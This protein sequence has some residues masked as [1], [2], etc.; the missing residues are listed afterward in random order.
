MLK[1]YFVKHF[2]IIAAVQILI[3]RPTHPGEMQIG[4]ESLNSGS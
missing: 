4:C 3:P 1:I 2:L